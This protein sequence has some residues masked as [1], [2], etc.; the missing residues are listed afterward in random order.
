MFYIPEVEDHTVVYCN[1]QNDYTDYTMLLYV[2]KI[3]MT[4]TS[5]YTCL[6]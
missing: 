1:T 3:S 6:T 5:T 4:G 2:N